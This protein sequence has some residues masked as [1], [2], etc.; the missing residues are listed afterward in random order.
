VPIIRRNNY[1]YVTPSTCYSVWTTVWYAGWN[2]AQNMQRKKINILRKIVHQVVFIYKIIQ[3][4][5]VNKT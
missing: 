5:T 3:G 2:V 4:C 1:I